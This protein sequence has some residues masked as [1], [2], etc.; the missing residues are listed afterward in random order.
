M[1]DLQHILW[2]KSGLLAY[3]VL[4]EVYQWLPNIPGLQ[5]VTGPSP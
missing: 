4:I 3:F 2:A 1:K 5:D